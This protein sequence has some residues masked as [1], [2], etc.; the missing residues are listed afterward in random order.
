MPTEKFSFRYVETNPELLVRRG[1]VKQDFGA[2]TVVKE[3]P[4][5][6]LEPG[7]VVGGLLETDLSTD[8]AVMDFMRE[9]GVVDRGHLGEGAWEDHDVVGLARAKFA[10]Q[11]VQAAATMWVKMRDG[12]EMDEEEL[13]SLWKNAH[14]KC[15]S[16]EDAFLRFHKVLE[17]GLMNVSAPRVQFCGARSGQIRYD[18]RLLRPVDL[19]SGL[20]VQL[21]GLIEAH[22]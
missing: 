20:L 1:K 8:E 16:A 15:S 4:P 19:I 9:Y 22:G 10:L 7:L 21:C 3:Y 12:G 5:A 14:Y 2:F 18:S 17:N 13:V 11:G 6:P